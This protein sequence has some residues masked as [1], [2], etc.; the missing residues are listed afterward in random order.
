MESKVKI[1]AKIILFTTLCLGTVIGV[2]ARVNVLTG[3]AETGLDYQDR[4]FGSD[5]GNNS[6]FTRLVITPSLRLNS[7]TERDGLEVF[8]APG[9][10]IDL[11]DND[12]QWNHDFSFSAYRFFTRQ[13]QL[14]LA[15]NFRKTDDP[16][17]IN[18][19]LEGGIDPEIS[20]D[21]GRRR[22]WTNR[23][24]L[25]SQYT[26]REDSIFSLG[27]TFSI[28]EN[29][30]SGVSTN[31]NYDRH[32]GFLGLTYR[33]NP[34]WKVLFD[35][36]YVRGL[37]DSANVGVGAPQLSDDLDEYR[38]DFTVKSDVYTNNPLSLR[39]SYDGVD[40][41][42]SSRDDSDIHQLT[43][44]WERAIS[45]RLSVGLGGGP[46]YI[47][48]EGQKSDWQANAYTSLTYNIE[49]GSLV[50]GAE[51]GVD[52]ENFSGTDQRGPVEFWQLDGTFTYDIT[53]MTA[54]SVFADYRDEDREDIITTPVGGIGFEEYNVE[55]YRG[56]FDIRHNFLQWFYVTMGYTYTD[57]S[58]DRDRSD[59]DEHR[60][61]LSL[62]VEKELL[63]W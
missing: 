35:G 52:L 30:D 45:P 16:G 21:L 32:E 42:E 31:Q 24:N 34:Q 50:L 57:S 28:L 48:T 10:S 29:D 63:R 51:S 36:R 40:F 55:R 62:G 20:G 27:Y 5:L 7:T 18:S 25:L 41:D 47:S 19:D 33:F 22:Y 61:L 6:N 15:N 37:Y 43:F 54:L 38:L 14:S 2:D 23:A 44:G 49:R 60:I 46:S 17:S 12:N 11:E 59:Y 3:G 9:Y 26:Y 4:S 39:Y 58:S 53:Q 13:W 56:G 1:N 8:Y